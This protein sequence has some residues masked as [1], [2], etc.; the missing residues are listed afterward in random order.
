MRGLQRVKQSVQT[1]LQLIATNAELE[2]QEL[3][4]KDVCLNRVFLG[5]PGTGEQGHSS[6]S[7]LRLGGWWLVAGGW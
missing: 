1:L 4:L 2:E 3:P 6:S 7:C 5:G